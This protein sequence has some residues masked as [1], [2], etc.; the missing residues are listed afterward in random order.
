MGILSKFV[1][2]DYK[3]LEKHDAGPGKH[4]HIHELLILSLKKV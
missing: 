1:S 4:I 3:I 2:D